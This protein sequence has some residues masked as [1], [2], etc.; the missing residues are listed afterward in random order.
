[1]RHGFLLINKPEGPTSHDIVSMVRRML[2]EKKIGHLGTL[3]PAAGGLLVLA[4]GAKALKVV[5]L[6]SDLSKEY[7]ADIRFGAVSATYDREGPIEEVSIKPGVVLPDDNAV[8]QMLRTR[9]VG[10]IEQV[11]PA[12]SA[13]KI[14]GERAYRKMRQGKPVDLPAREV[15]IDDCSLLSYAYPDLKLSVACGS[16][17]YIRSL[18]HDLGQALHVGG[19]LT[20]LKRTRVGDWSLDDAVQPD[21]VQWGHVIP[22]KEILKNMPSV[23]LSSDQWK[24]VSH[25]QCIDGTCTSNT[26]A[27]HEHLPVAILEQK[28]PGLMKARKVL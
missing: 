2:P 16:G 17:T 15:H 7:E 6:F 27:W 22:L 11:P 18:A 24:A 21:D 10:T 25:G 14:G 23:T 3:D 8:L 28:E 1:M 19:Y 26:I 4:V 12:A 20:A 9:F 5:E 13:V